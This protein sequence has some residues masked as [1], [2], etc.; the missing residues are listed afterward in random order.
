VSEKSY[1]A[2]IKSGDGASEKDYMK[3]KIQKEKSPSKNKT[4]SIKSP[5]FNTILP[6]FKLL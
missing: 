5:L 6:Q 3:P 2:K 4:P 1:S